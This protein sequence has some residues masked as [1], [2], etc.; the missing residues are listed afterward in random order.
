MSKDKN[1]D[2]AS[3]RRNSA[4]AESREQRVQRLL[5]HE[6]GPLI[7]WL[8]DEARRRRMELNEMAEELGVTYG[9]INQLRTGIRKTNQISYV[10]ARACAEFLGV[11]IV[12]VHL[13]SGFLSMEDFLLPAES[14]EQRLDRAIR[15]MQD[16]PSVRASVHID[17]GE[18]D[19]EGK[20]AMVLM[21]AQA[22]GQDL[23]GLH[24]LPVMLRWL[25]RAAVIH[26]EN[27][28]AAE[29]GHRDTLARAG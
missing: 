8:F 29:K 14:E 23:L 10:V 13:L 1:K 16:D 21:Y 27:Q 4:Q 12:V 26:D 18:L 22:T 11:P 20:R 2:K 15:Q 5:T 28:F 3:G 19:I 24:E 7:A 6:G 25:Q 17:L 9:Y